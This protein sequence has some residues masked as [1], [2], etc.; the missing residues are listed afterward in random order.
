MVP[1]NNGMLVTCFKLNKMTSET[2]YYT[3]VSF[4]RIRYILCIFEKQKESPT[5]INNYT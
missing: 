5:S 2:T 4:T 3:Q 1:H